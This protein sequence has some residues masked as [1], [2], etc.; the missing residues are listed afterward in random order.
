MG[1]VAGSESRIERAVLSVD[2]KSGLTVFGHGLSE[3]GVEL[4]ATGGTRRALEAD[5]VAVRSAEEL[6]GIGSWFT[7][8]IKTLHP[9][10][11]GGVLAPRTEEGRQELAALYLLPFDLVVVNF[12]PFERHLADHPT[13]DDREEYIDIGGVTL[14]R[15]AAKNHRWVT[16]VTD[17][18]EYPGLLEELRSRSGG[19]SAATR[20]RLAVRTFERCTEYDAA[21][22]RGLG[23]AAGASG[24]SPLVLLIPRDPAA[25]RSG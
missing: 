17:P 13:A 4:W 23:P 15:A 5:R 9:G 8:R 20:R 7:G 18:G 10:I 21:I 14:A 24:V 6:T 3:L 11:L 25:P 2:D 1:A 19:V 22:S 16:V 12:Y